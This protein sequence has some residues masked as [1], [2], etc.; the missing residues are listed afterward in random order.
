LLSLGLTEAGFQMDAASR[1]LFPSDNERFGFGVT[2][3]KGDIRQYDVSRLSAGWYVNWGTLSNLYHP[4]S[5]EFVQIIRTSNAG[6]SPGKEA[7]ATILARYPGMLWLVG[8]EPDCPYQDNTLPDRYAE[9]Y[10]DVYT[11]LKEKDPT[12]KVA[13]GG[14]VQATP[15]RLQWLDMVW[16]AY[17][18]KYGQRMPVDVW[19]VHAFV[20]REKRDP[21]SNWGCGIPPGVNAD[22]GLLIGIQD[23]DNMDYFRAHIVAMRRWMRDKGEQNKPLI[24]SEYGILFNEELGYSLDRVRTYMLNTFDYFLRATDPSIGYPA[25]GYRLVQRWAWYSL[26]DNSFGW[27]T[28]WS[29]LFNPDTKQITPLGEA[30]GNYA[31]A[32]KTL[33]VD[34]FPSRFEWSATTTPVYGQPASLT[35]RTAVANNGN[36]ATSKPVTVRF[37]N[38]NP[39]AGGSLLGSGSAATVPARY[40]GETNVSLLWNTSILGPRTLYT[41]I[42]GTVVGDIDSTNNQATVSIDVD[43]AVTPPTFTPPSPVYSPASPVTVTVTTLVSNPGDAAVENVT[44][45]LWSGSP[46]S[47]TRL[48]TTIL[49]RLDPGQSL[50]V[51]FQWQ[52]LDVGK[53]PVTALVD[54]GGA[55]TESDEGNNIASAT[56][57]V[58]RHRL[59]GP[60]IR[61]KATSP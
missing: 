24:V 12:A 32:R 57:L 21:P 54:V 56:F 41:R 15:L 6:F 61:R 29:A 52:G 53:H 8:N 19:N 4:D 43:L 14:V 40:M 5:L 9:I 30:F 51:S 1:P 48:T 59:F 27:G 39:D 11:F 36:A 25:D 23:L 3:Q 22:Q 7:L 10:H 2:G 16:N 17:Q 28:T 58:A 38:G 18:R 46:G 35:L 44:T 37:W 60:V 26:D 47:G 20:L 50:P 45:E 55:V 42:D 34:L 33:Y 49:P 13:I 31:R